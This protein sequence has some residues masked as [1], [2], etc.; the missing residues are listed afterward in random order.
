MPRVTQGRIH[1]FKLRVIYTLISFP[2]MNHSPLVL[3]V[4]TLLNNKLLLQIKIQVLATITTTR[5]P[6]IQ[7]RKSS[8]TTPALQVCKP[9]ARSQVL[10]KRRSN[11]KIAYRVMKMR[12]WSRKVPE[13]YLKWLILTLTKIARRLKLL[14]PKLNRRKKRSMFHRR[15]TPHSQL[16]HQK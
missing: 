12:Q 7:C 8:R 14:N 15:K 10:S 4:N 6:S 13:I 11:G 16:D 3:V 9:I 5:N 1:Q 2:M